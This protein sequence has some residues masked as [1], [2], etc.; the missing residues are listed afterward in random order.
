MWF[1][2]FIHSTSTECLF[3]RPCYQA[4]GA[5]VI[6]AGSF[7]PIEHGKNNGNDRKQTTPGDFLTSSPEGEVDFKGYTGLTSQQMLSMGLTGEQDFRRP[8]V[9]GL[10][11]RASPTPSSP[12]RLSCRK[13]SL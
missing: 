1:W 8:T 13:L 12:C 5:Q 10:G 6:R 7:I 11:T 9:G 3:S 2:F 4:R